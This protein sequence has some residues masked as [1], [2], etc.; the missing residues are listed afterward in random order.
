[1]TRLSLEA[2]ISLAVAALV[3]STPWVAHACP[4]CFSSGE[5]DDA[6]LYGSL[7]MMIVP[8]LTLGSLGYWAYRRLKAADERTIRPDDVADDGADAVVL[9]ISSHR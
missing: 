4:M 8:V 1:M 3:V 6:F 9:P 5:N 2:W 7:F